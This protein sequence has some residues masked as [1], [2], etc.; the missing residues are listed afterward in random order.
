MFTDR[1]G[2]IKAFEVMEVLARAQELEAQGHRV[3]HFEV[4][5]PDFPTAQPIVDAGLA[6]LTDGQTKYTIA[7]GI[8]PLRECIA[9]HYADA[10]VNLSPERI[11]VTA[12][13]SGGLTLLTALLL[14]PSDQMLITDP[15]YPCNE[16]FTR[17]VGA[18]PVPIPVGANQRFQ[19]S[20]EDIAARWTPRTRGVLLAS[21]AN[22]TGTMLSRSELS[23]IANEVRQRGGFFVLDEIYQG[24]TWHGEYDTGLQVAPDLYVLNSFSKF[25]GMTG[26]RLGWIVVPEA[27]VEPVTKLA[28]NLFIAP[29]TIAQH[30]AVA[31]FSAAA[32][33]IHRTRAR[34][35]EER[36]HLLTNGLAALGFQV[37][38]EPDG[39]FYLYVDISHTG[40]DSHTF[41][42]RLLDEF[43]VAATP[44]ADFGQHLQDR[45]VR[46]AFTTDTQSIE[47]GIER[48]AAALKQWGARA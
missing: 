33:N 17:L 36:C 41:C 30:A 23:G 39:A 3:V 14:G 4:G 2:A 35:F 26:W 5:E 6:A 12:G 10:G 46:F 16:V 22:P 21:P 32:M 15:G 31:A 34:T 9:E 43:H 48:I 19:P 11:V 25:F 40:F 47:L 13:A 44:G 28:Q 38:I 24:I 37:S 8:L 42:W 27:A 45:F 20:V 29:S 18:E 1:V 7:T